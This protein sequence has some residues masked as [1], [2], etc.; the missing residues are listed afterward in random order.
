MHGGVDDCLN[1]NN[2]LRRT[3]RNAGDSAKTQIFFR[4]RQ[5]DRTARFL[6]KVEQAAVP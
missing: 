3:S 5:F 2:D 1:P 4:V 6:Y